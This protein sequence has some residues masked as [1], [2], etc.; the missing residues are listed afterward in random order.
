M[1]KWKK[2]HNIS[3][4]SVSGEAGAADDEAMEKWLTDVWKILREGYEMDN[5]YNCDE[6]G[7]FYKLLPDKTLNRKGKTCTGGKLSKERLTV[8]LC[9]NASGTDKLKPLVIGKYENPRCFSAI[10]KNALP[11]FYYSNSRAWMTQ[12]VI[13]NS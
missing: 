5:I 6:S 13:T 8:L 1:D 3:F 2:R 7:L 4:Q 9:A 11:V 12:N 10:K